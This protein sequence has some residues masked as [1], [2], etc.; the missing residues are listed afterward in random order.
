MATWRVTLLEHAYRTQ[1]IVVVAADAD[2]AETLA[3]ESVREADWVESCWEADI[4][5]TEIAE[6]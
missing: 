3:W 1:E 4:T 6:E 5:A 2:H